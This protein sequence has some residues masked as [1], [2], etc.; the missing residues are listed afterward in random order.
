MELKTCNEVLCHSKFLH[1]FATHESE[2]F[3][4]GK[5]VTLTAIDFISCNMWQFFFLLD[6]TNAPKLSCIGRQILIL[7]PDQQISAVNNQLLNQYNQ[8]KENKRKWFL[9]SDSVNVW[10]WTWL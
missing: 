2:P 3:R 4:I 7:A 9:I 1:Q 10:F 8:L 5:H 6:S